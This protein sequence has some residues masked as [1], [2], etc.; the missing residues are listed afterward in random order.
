MRGNEREQ[1]QS[2]AKQRKGKEESKSFAQKDNSC[3][4]TQTKNKKLRRGEGPKTG[5]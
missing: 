5:N 2:K 3:L 4:E 1:K